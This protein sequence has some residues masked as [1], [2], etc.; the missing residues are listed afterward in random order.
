[1]KQISIEKA[2]AGMVTAKPVTDARGN[3]LVKEGT[4]LTEVWIERLRN[5]GV[6]ALHIESEDAG[7]KRGDAE[8]R[9]EL[10][11]VFGDVIRDDLMLKIKAAAYNY[12]V[13]KYT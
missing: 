5:R 4:E 8:I 2:E 7:P 11:S 10:D 9:T 6:Q 13:K 12:L 1:M 3:L